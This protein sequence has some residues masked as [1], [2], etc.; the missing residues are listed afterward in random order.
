MAR[1][2]FLS[3]ATLA[4]FFCAFVLT[5]SVAPSNQPPLFAADEKEEE[6][7]YAPEYPEDEPIDV[8]PTEIVGYRLL[9]TF[10]FTDSNE[11]IDEWR[12]NEVVAL[13]RGP[14]ALVVEMNA[15]D[16]YFFS[17]AL[18]DIPQGSIVV[19]MRLR[20]ANAGVG[21]LFFETADHTYEEAHSTQFKLYNDDK[22]HDYAVLLDADAPILNV[23]FD[24]GGNAGIAELEK[25]EFFA[26]ETKPLKFGVATL[27]DGRLLADLVN[28]NPEVGQVVDTEIYG[29]NAP[30]G[31]ATTAIKV[32]DH[33][34]VE[35][36][37]PQ[38]RP[39]EEM[40][41]VAKVRATGE[42]MNRR[43]FAF[44][45]SACA[46][47]P[48]D[49]NQ[50]EA[51]TLR[52]GKLAVRFAPDASG[53]EIFR[54]GVRVAV[55]APLLCEEGD[56]ADIIAPSHDFEKEFAQ[57]QAGEKNAET[58]KQGRLAPVFRSIS[59]QTSEV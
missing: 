47:A 2:N 43:F 48:G 40:E 58:P 55:I 20:R 38:K 13:S 10:D 8:A 32:A 16:P 9:K 52:S 6:T 4:A 23:R 28:S 44:N 31:A 42:I 25:I 21:Q 51:P 14:R 50:D 3:T 29:V 33:A 30:K 54:D 45:E 24:I 49:A 36:S 46:P 56:G 53:A 39:F 12:P 11:S 41:I 19:R 35:R 26:I 22:F 57:F 17:P 18:D 59:C 15:E 37:Y 1:L 27:E 34:L 5:W 7:S